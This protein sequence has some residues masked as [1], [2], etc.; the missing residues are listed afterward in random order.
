MESES[1]LMIA[2]TLSNNLGN[3]RK[4]HSLHHSMAEQESIQFYCHSV[5]VSGQNAALFLEVPK[6][7]LVVPDDLSE[8]QT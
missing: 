3:S 1:G 6:V 2:Q 7:W 8:A 5:A 4:Q